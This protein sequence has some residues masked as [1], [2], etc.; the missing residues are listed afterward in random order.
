MSASHTGP[1]RPT[2][3][4]PHIFDS[5]LALLVEMCRISSPSGDLDGLQRGMGLY[6]ERLADR[7][8]EVELR[9]H[10]VDGQGELP[11]LV[12]R[13]SAASRNETGLFL[14]GHM[15]TVLPA[16]APEIRD[17]RLYGTGAVDMK[18]G[19]ACFLGAV[20]LL[21]AE[22]RQ[23][24]ED[25]TLVVVPDEEVAGPV[26]HEAMARYGATARALWVLEPGRPAADADH[27]TGESETGASETI[28]QT[29]R[30]LTTWSLDVR[31]RGAHAGNG[32]WQGRSAA[33]G[34]AHWVQGALAL[35]RPGL[36][37]T[38]NVGRI[39]AGERDFVEQL[40]QNADLV[41]SGRQT[42]VVPDRAVVEGEMRFVT[43]EEG[44][45]L[46]KE[47]RALAD[48]VADRDELSL[49]FEIHKRVPPCPPSEPGQRLA[50][51][52]V[53][54]ARDRG[55]SLEVEAD[56]GGISFP[57]ML[58]DPAALPVLDGLGPVGGG[59]HTR[60][61]FVE[62]RSLDRRARL[63]ADLLLADLDRA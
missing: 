45:A 41:H 8:L 6:G 32:Y 60:E 24:P 16:A 9:P 35:A 53:Q 49:R 25:L 19:L 50:Q 55:W 58:P 33:G 5:T 29:R 17:G 3:A 36:G 1:F 4:P 18:G 10:P 47:L 38:V 23:L 59:M 40:G 15:D 27:E 11:V 37:P 12:A 63:L 52:A 31:G 14:I 21:Q 13:G 48:A 46:E 62:L 56:R 39:V 54:A 7:G 34:A 57:N 42:N 28:V 26:C 61:E 51:A 30:G 20:D 22:G 43:A 44:A 2:L